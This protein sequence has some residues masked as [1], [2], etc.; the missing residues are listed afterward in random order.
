[1]KKKVMISEIAI[2]LIINTSCRKIIWYCSGA[3][4]KRNNTGAE[5]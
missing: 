1:M 5:T 2:I 3:E 4:G